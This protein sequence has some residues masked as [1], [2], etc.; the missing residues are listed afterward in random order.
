MIYNTAAMRNAVLHADKVSFPT[1]MLPVTRGA[2]NPVV[3]ETVT[4]IPLMT[5]TRDGGHMSCS[6]K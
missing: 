3:E 4:D 5:P 2:M 6:P 1:M